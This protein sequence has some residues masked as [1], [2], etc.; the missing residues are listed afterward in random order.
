MIFENNTFHLSDKYLFFNL[1][2]SAEL[3]EKHT[4]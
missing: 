3:K 1:C 4:F 2:L